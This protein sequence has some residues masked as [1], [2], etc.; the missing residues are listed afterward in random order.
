MKLTL[1]AYMNMI[2]LV[3][4]KKM[5]CIYNYRDICLR[6]VQKNSLNGEKD[7]QPNEKTKKLRQPELA[8]Q[9]I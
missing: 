4:L 8:K 5:K 6:H 2:F 9:I 1:I 3:C 7:F